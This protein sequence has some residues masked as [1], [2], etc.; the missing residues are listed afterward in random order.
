M[1]TR[2]LL[3]NSA[4]TNSGTGAESFKLKP[5]RDGKY[6]II[7]FDIDGSR[8]EVVTDVRTLYA[9]TD[10]LTQVVYGDRKP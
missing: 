7:F 2:I 10:A 9:L 1:R 5:R 4:L 8:S 6:E 3:V